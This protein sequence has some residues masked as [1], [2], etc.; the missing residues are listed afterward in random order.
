MHKNILT[1]VGI[2]ILFLGLCITPS[3]AINNVKKT[4]NTIGSGNTL[5]VGGTGPGN[6]STIQSAINDASDGDTVFVYNGIYYEN[7][8]VD[9]SINLKGEDRNSTII[10]TWDCEPIIKITADWVNF[11]S[12]TLNGGVGSSNGI[13]ISSNYNTILDNN[14]SSYYNGIF[15]SSF[16]IGNCI[17]SNIIKGSFGYSYGIELSDFSNNNTIVGNNISINLCGV[18]LSNSNKG[19][20]ITNNKFSYNQQSIHL[21]FSENNNIVENNYSN[22]EHEIY[23][24]KSH[25]NTISEN[26]FNNTECCNCIILSHSNSNIVTRNNF[27][28]KHATS[29]IL[30]NSK[31]NV[32][33]CNKILRGLYG[34]II[35][36]SYYNSITFNSFYNC[37][38]YYDGNSYHNNITNNTVN[39]KALVYVVN[40]SDADIN[41]DAGQII[42]VNCKNITI[43]Y[44]NLSNTTVGIQL[45][46]SNNCSIFNNNFMNNRYCC[47]CL[48]GSINNF[49]IDNNLTNNGFGVYLE[50]SSD[51][52]IMDNNLS[53]GDQYGIFIASH[54][55][56]NTI[57]GNILWKYDVNGISISSSDNNSVMFNNISNSYLGIII[58]QSSKNKINGN[59]I[60]NSYE[61]IR[62][63]SY[64]QNNII[65]ENNILNN[66]DGITFYHGDNDNNYIF[67]NNFINNVRNAYIGNNSISKSKWDDGYPSGGNYWDDYDGVD[68]FSGPNQDIPG[69]DGIGDTR[70]IIPSFLYNADRYPLMEPWYGNHPPEAP[71]FDIPSRW[72]VRVE[73]CFTIN[74]TDPDNDSIKYIIDWGDGTIDETNYYDSGVFIEICHTWEKKG[75]YIIKIRVVDNFDYYSDWSEFEVTIPRTRAST[76]TMWYQWLMLRFP[77]LERLL[78]LL[79]L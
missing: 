9:K 24:T 41:V 1:V 4:T 68:N 17:R 20:N 16:T 18:S 43:R 66:D 79:L 77:L 76:N 28:P 30:C 31:N 36:N 74:S 59:Y 39:D 48:D 67:H 56:N 52:I 5:Y 57:K 27:N 72:P 12:F 78:S 49:I 25:N 40:E 23:L 75:L 13:L 10:Y 73:L 11:S 62:L 63:S 21:S 51:N 71:D 29:I 32:I 70:Y 6:Y 26:I 38:F 8:E 55:D 14:I 47:I 46:S 45:W 19:N 69:R 2:T 44:Q 61:G 50:D 64:S 53:L 54:S 35:S 33:K 37:G 65:T 34:M 58:D 7:I 60:T 42:L 15:L 3:F 22:N